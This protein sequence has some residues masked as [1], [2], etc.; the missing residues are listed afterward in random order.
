MDDIA[1]KPVSGG[2]GVEV[3]NVNI[4]ETLTDPQ[5]QLIQK[6]FVDNGLVFLRDQT[7]TPDQHI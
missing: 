1:I 3:T 7:I 5:F 4:D 2:V 6:A